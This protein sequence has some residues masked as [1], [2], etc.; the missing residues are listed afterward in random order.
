MLTDVFLFGWVMLFGALGGMAAGQLAER[1]NL[2]TLGNTLAGLIGGMLGGQV[3]E[4]SWGVSPLALDRWALDL[5]M[6]ASQAAASAVGGA[7][8]MVLVGA[9]R[10][11]L[12]R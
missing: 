1:L 3:L 2:R 11:T 12:Q 10:R 8:I 4:R 6:L 7:A 9:L 5:G